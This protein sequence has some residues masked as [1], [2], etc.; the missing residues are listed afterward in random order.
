MTSLPG[1]V[2]EGMLSKAALDSTSVHA[3]EPVGQG[4][5][6]SAVRISYNPETPLYGQH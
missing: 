5:S 2:R 1:S 6:S 3:G 4:I